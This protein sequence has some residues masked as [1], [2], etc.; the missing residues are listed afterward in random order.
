[1]IVGGDEFAMK[2][3]AHELSGLTAYLD[4]ILQTASQRKANVNPFF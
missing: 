1:M 4:T 2:A 3:A